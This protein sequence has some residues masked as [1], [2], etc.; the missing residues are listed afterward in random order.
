M[1]RKALRVPQSLDEKWLRRD[2]QMLFV[3]NKTNLAKIQQSRRLFKTKTSEFLM[4]QRIEDR[5]GPVN[6]SEHT[7]RSPAG[8]CGLL[9]SQFP[10]SFLARLAVSPPSKASILPI[11]ADCMVCNILFICVTTEEEMPLTVFS[12]L[13]ILTSLF[14]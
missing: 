14:C 9:D 7:D 6:A 2:C 4:Q 12:M 13:F 11:R 5:G 3:F 1:Q 8:F 10:P